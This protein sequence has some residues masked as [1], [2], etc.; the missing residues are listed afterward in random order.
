MEAWRPDDIW[1]VKDEK[2]EVRLLYLWVVPARVGGR[3]Q[4]QIPVLSADQRFILEMN[5]DL[6]DIEGTALNQDIKWRI[7]NASLNGDQIRFSLISEAD[8]RMVR[9]DYQG[10][11]RGNF[12]NG[13][14]RLSGTI[15]P[16][17]LEWQA[18]R[19]KD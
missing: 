6:Q 13:T 17:E 18:V 4:W 2:G 8:D 3:W 15:D 10:Q 5:Q 1:M 19:V 7:F 12:I 11:V 14:V 9:Q 16:E